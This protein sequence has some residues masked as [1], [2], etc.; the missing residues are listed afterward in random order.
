MPG[1][2][3]SFPVLIPGQ[4]NIA[5][6][7]AKFPTWPA[8]A[9]S[10]GGAHEQRLALLTVLAL[11]VWRRALIIRQQREAAGQRL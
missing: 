6:S 4:T 10:L 7:S 9:A 1:A 2:F 8:S 11:E 5:V 3:T